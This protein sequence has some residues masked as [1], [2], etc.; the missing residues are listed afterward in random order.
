MA[1][2]RRSAARDR[3]PPEPDRLQR[4]AQRRRSKFCGS[5]RNCAPRKTHAGTG[6]CSHRRRRR[7]SRISARRTP[8]ISAGR[9]LEKLRDAGGRPQK[10]GFAERA[11]GAV[12]RAP[13]HFQQKRSVRAIALAGVQE[14]LPVLRI[15]EIGAF[16]L[17]ASFLLAQR[18]PRA[19]PRDR[20]DRAGICGRKIA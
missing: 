15:L 8:A 13:D 14:F 12:R 4:D 10:T 2:A 20:L 16:L 11:K 6:D 18:L 19:R 3:A 9:F 5:R 17:D 1:R 7:G